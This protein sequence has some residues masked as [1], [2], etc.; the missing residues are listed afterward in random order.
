MRIIENLIDTLNCDAK[1]K[2]II[3]GPFQTAV[4]TRNCGI[5]STPH[6][7]GKH[8][9][10]AAVREAGELTKKTA[11]ELAG[12]ALSVNHFE[13]AI[14]MAAINPL[15]DVDEERCVEINAADILAEKGEGRRIA[16]VG[17]F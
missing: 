7:N 8:Q 14:G 15:I 10:K 5:A 13:A 12:M 4:L 17:H 3:Q 6:E 9:E 2:D 1:V 16:I 11:S